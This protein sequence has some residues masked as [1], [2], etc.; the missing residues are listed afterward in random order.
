MLDGSHIGTDYSITYFEE[1]F[2]KEIFLKL[3]RSSIVAYEHINMIC[4]NGYIKMN[5]GKEIKYKNRDYRNLQK[6]VLSFRSNH[7]AIL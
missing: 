3:S 1:S 4:P 6:S 2:D 7:A 5:D